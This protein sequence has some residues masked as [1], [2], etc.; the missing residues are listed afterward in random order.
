MN[1]PG[2]GNERLHRL[3]Q[4]TEGDQIH[5]RYMAS[6]KFYLTFQIS[7]SKSVKWDSSED[8]LLNEHMYSSYSKPDTGISLNK[9]SVSQNHQENSNSCIQQEYCYLTIGLR[10]T[11]LFWTV[12]ISRPLVWFLFCLLFQFFTLSFLLLSN[13]P[14][15]STIPKPV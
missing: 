8:W 2:Y 15:S 11:T 14:I 6:A 10:T 4:E 7:I 12:I 5:L 1:T 3:W 13:F 9:C